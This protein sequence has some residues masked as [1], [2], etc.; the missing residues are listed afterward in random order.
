MAT[1]SGCGENVDCKQDI[2][3]WILLRSSLF[4]GSSALYSH[5]TDL[6]L[7][8]RCVTQFAKEDIKHLWLALQSVGYNLSLEKIYYGHEQQLKWND[9]IHLVRLSE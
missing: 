7:L 9:E 2:H 8:Y 6:I 4:R 1:V 5:K 3:P